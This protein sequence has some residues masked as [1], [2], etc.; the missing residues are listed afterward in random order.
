MPDGLAHRPAADRPAMGERLSLTR[1]QLSPILRRHMRCLAQHKPT[2]S[3]DGV[4][5]GLLI[6]WA[7]AFQTKA[8]VDANSRTNTSPPVDGSPWAY[9]GRVNCC[10]GV[11]IANGWVLTAFHAGAGN[12]NFGGTLFHYD[13]LSRQLTNSDGSATDLILF[14]LNPPPSLPPLAL[15]ATTPP[16][17]TEVSMIGFGHWA[18]SAQTNWGSS[19]GFYW[20][21]LGNKS[22][23]NNRVAAV[24]LEVDDGVGVFTA[25][26]TEFDAPPGQT[27]HEGQGAPGDSG[28]GIFQLVGSSWQL[29]G[30]ML[31]IS[32]PFP[33]QPSNSSAFGQS[34][35]SA[36][37]A[38]YRSQMLSIIS[39]TPP[40]LAISRSGTNVMVC[41]PD[42]GVSYTLQSATDLAAPA[43]T[44][45]AQNQ[46]PTNAQIC[47]SVAPT[48]NTVF[49][50]LQK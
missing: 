12:A 25:L 10:G 20:S 23:G 39:S 41:W 7:G 34:T 33:G 17:S 38:A 5:I 8:V 1:P 24:G 46:F 26:S 40:V 3:P 49:F 19:I 30:I 2:P 36:D 14:H 13:G 29:A 11:Y 47:V 50:R 15:A 48:D 35:Y 42:T 21:P 16:V 43:W 31:D 28:G 4:M 44:T 45:V 22:W 9:V 32:P 6:L 37:V 27:S 18:G